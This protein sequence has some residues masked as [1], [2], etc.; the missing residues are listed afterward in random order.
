LI[1]ANQA[2]HILLGVKIKIGILPAIP[3]VAGSAACPVGL[4]ADAEVVEQVL[5]PNRDRLRV[6]PDLDGL[7]CQVNALCHHLSAAWGWHSRQ[8]A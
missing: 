3:G 6:V 4:D 8:A 7:S 2:V 1:V 5:F